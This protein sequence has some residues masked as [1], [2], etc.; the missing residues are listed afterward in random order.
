MKYI[1]SLFTIL[2]LSLNLYSQGHNNTFSTTAEEYN[3]VTNGMKLQIENGLDL[4]KGYEIQP[5]N[6]AGIKYA[7]KNK[8]KWSRKTEFFGVYKMDDKNDL[9]PCAILMTMEKTNSS[10]KSWYCIPMFDSSDELWK[11]ART[12]YFNITKSWKTEKSNA[13]RDYTWGI[14][15]TVSK[16][17]SQNPQIGLG[18]QS[19]SVKFIS[20]EFIEE[21]AYESGEHSS[22]KMKLTFEKYECAPECRPLNE[23]L[24]L[25]YNV[26]VGEGLIPFFRSDLD[27]SSKST[28]SKDYIFNIWYHNNTFKGIS[29]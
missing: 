18:Q 5:I 4:N 1:I 25:Y 6:S 19:A 2:S 11:Q 22:G 7:P 16:L 20:A 12:D 23:K 26:D 28:Y 24:I 21:I 17:F 27:I 14:I 8:T 15:K 9:T 29:Y 13:P 10:Y 3:Y